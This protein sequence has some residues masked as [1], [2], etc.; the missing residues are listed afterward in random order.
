MKARAKA[1]GLTQFATDA[2]EVMYRRCKT[3]EEQD[4]VTKAFGDV[5]DGWKKN[6]DAF[7]KVRQGFLDDEPGEEDPP[8][9]QAALARS[10]LTF[11][12]P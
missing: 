8:S 10:G 11:L 1:Y 9:L 12:K 7:A 6:K 3:T 5:V 4:Q 2:F